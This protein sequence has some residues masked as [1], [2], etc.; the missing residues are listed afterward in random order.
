MSNRSGPR[1]I[2]NINQRLRKTS[3]KIETKTL[4]IAEVFYPEFMSN[5]HRKCAVLNLL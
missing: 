3:P 4:A 2:S 1:G 5:N